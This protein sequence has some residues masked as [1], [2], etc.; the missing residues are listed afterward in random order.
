VRGRRCRSI[1]RPAF[2][3][4]TSIAMA[5]ASRLGLSQDERPSCS[6]DGLLL[7]G[8]DGFAASRARRFR[9]GF[10][11]SVQVRSP[12]LA[13]AWCPCRR[14]HTLLCRR[15]VGSESSHKWLKIVGW[16]HATLTQ[17]IRPD[18][19]Y[20]PDGLPKSRAERIR[21]ISPISAAGGVL[22]VHTRARIARGRAHFARFSNLLGIGRTEWWREL[23]SNCRA[24]S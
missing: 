17:Q 12:S 19:A 24:T 16:R 4:W 23:N 7:R 18:A 5:A 10:G 21:P 1:G 14:E 9:R 20:L 13:R 6:S 11:F 8:R 3:Y 2:P 22:R 15:D